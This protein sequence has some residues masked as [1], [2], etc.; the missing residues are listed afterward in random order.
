MDAQTCL[1]KTKRVGTLALATVDETGAPQI[2]CVSAVH[3][4]SDALYFF[5]A[6]GKEMTRQLLADGRIR[7]MVHTR[8]N[9]M[10]RMSGV[11]RPAPKEE[12]RK[13]IDIIFEEQ[14]YLANVY[15]GETREI[16]IIFEIRDI[17]IDY[18]NLGVKPIERGTYTLEHEIASR[19]GYRITNA[20]IGCGTC[21]AHCPQKCIIPG[22][23]YE[24]NANHCLHCGACEKACPV[25][26]V[27]N[28]A[29]F[30]AN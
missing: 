16:C 9:E 2:R 18:F 19:K 28:L 13:W 23:P 14:P 26:A 25:S 30:D 20:C 12:Q 7:T 21:L 3:Y 17:V 6:Q 15:P 8:F 24:I 29:S 10:I 5:T 11:A 27:E 4:E 22:E 1:E